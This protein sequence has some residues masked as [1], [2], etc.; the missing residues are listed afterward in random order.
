MAPFFPEK[1]S[2][3]VSYIVPKARLWERGQS[4]QKCWRSLGYATRPAAPK[5]GRCR[6]RPA[7]EHPR[8]PPAFSR[9]PT[10]SGRTSVPR[11]QYRSVSDKR[12]PRQYRCRT[13][14]TDMPAPDA[15]R[16]YRALRRGPR[17]RFGMEEG[18]CRCAGQS[19]G[20]RR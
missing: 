2:V 5:G 1:F 13:T 15:R 8:Y 6:A 18:A 14:P 17:Q 16:G 3:S 19:R 7:T 9:E 12:L 20:R 4:E 11:A 10:L